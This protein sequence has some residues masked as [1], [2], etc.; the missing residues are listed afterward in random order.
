MSEGSSKNKLKMAIVQAKKIS[1][2]EKPAKDPSSPAIDLASLIA[3]MK[4]QKRDYVF[5]YKATA[6]KLDPVNATAHDSDADSD[7]DKT[8]E[9]ALEQRMMQSTALRQKATRAMKMLMSNCLQNSFL[10]WKGA[11]QHH[12][13]IR[14]L[15]AH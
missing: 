8:N 2:A 6:T 3:Q 13:R 12:T 10:F 4:Q 11:P 15:P 1:D 5:A 14:P 9:K 7:T